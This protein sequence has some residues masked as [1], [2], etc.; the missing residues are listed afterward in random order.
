MVMVR[1]R[2]IGMDMGG[3]GLRLLRMDKIGRSRRNKQQGEHQQDETA[4]HVHK[5]TMPL[6]GETAKRGIV[7]T[8]VPPAPLGASSDKERPVCAPITLAF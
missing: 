5:A 6:S 7:T 1:R 8:A 4:Q 3:R 2:P